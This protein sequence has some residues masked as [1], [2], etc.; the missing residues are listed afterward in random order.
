MARGTLPPCS[1][2]VYKKNAP[3][4]HNTRGFFASSADARANR[5]CASAIRSRIAAG[6]PI[7]N[8]ASHPLTSDAAA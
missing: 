8:V 2:G 4:V 1:F 5:T 3:C 7:E 6:S